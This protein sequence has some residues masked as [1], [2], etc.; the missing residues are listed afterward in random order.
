MCISRGGRPRWLRLKHEYYSYADQARACYASTARLRPDRRRGGKPLTP[1]TGDWATE[2]I[3]CLCQ[4]RVVIIIHTIM[5]EMASAL[6]TYNTYIHTNTHTII[7][8]LNWEMLEFIEI[9]LLTRVFFLWN[10]WSLH[11]SLPLLCRRNNWEIIEM[12]DFYFLCVC[13]AHVCLHVC[14]FACV[15]TFCDLWGHKFV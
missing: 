1:S 2:T 15:R 4:T 7:W 14:V 9:W 10:C 3:H 12:F 11:Y 13:R 5:K 8:S 6:S